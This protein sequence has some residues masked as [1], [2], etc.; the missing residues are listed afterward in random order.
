MAVYMQVEGV[1]GDVS[2]ENHVD[3][4]PLQEVKLPTS[5]PDVN[6][7]AG[8]I[9]DRTTSQVTFEDIEISKYMDKASPDLMKWNIRGDTKLVTI[10][11]CKEN[12]APVLQLVLKD[13]ILTN[14]EPTSDEEGKV[15][16]SISLDYTHIEYN[17]TPYDAKNKAKPV[18]RAHY[19]LEKAVGS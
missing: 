15:E 16:E 11:I 14:Y 1:K 3:W 2:Q 9:S 5:R 8:N 19:D 13:V 10:E 18:Q 4:I 7:T 6:T 17:Y 12:G